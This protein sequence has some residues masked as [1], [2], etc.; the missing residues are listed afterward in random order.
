[1]SN[2]I[3]LAEAKAHLDIPDAETS[4]D[5]VL[6][7]LI[8]EA[9]AAIESYIDRKVIK[10]TYTEYQDGRNSNRILLRHYPADK[11]TE[12]RIDYQSEFTDADTLL[13]TDEYEVDQVGNELLLLHRIWPKGVRNIKVVYEAGL[14]V[15]IASVPSDISGACLWV[16]EWFY[17]LRKNRRL[18]NK[19]VG[20][21]NETTR[22][23]DDWPEWLHRQLDKYKRGPF[24]FIANMPVLNR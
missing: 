20:K 9:S 2:L 4:E 12:V 15:D 10:Q 6:N 3:T 17:E 24:D 18:L 16:T 11:P 22:Y 14:A 19:S 5:D 8:A 21:N 7:R 23:R 1:M 13:E